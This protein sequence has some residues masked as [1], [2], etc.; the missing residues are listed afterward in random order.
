MTDTNSVFVSGGTGYLGRHL[1]P[2]LSRRG[3]K[4]RILVRPG[5]EG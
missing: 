5:S 4:V 3:H 2:A 1:I